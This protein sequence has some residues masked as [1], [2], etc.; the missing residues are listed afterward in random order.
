MLSCHCEAARRGVD[1][2]KRQR[3]IRAGADVI[4]GDFLELD[5]LMRFLGL[6]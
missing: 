6:E 3:L 4:T 5:A 2:V 1:P